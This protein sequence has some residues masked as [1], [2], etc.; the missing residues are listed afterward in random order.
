TEITK[1]LEAFGFSSTSALTNDRSV[2]YTFHDGGNV[3][4]VAPG[5]SDAVTQTVHVTDPVTGQ[6]YYRINNGPDDQVGSI[7][8]DG[9]GRA[10]V[11][12]T[13][14]NETSIAID[15]AA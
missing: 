5:A 4:D 15:P 1:L 11:Y 6:L 3:G 8:A 9:T 10:T 12:A 2:T 7:H 14:T 13:A